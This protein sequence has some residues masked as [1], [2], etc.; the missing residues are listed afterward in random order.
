MASLCE[1]DRGRSYT[2]LSDVINS[3][4]VLCEVLCKA[5]QLNNQGTINEWTIQTEDTQVVQTIL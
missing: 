4:R 1:D 3:R 2:S 5:K